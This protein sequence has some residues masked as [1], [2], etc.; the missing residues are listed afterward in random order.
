MA[1][2]ARLSQGDYY[3]RYDFEE[4]LY[5]WELASQK[6]FCKFFDDAKEE[7]VPSNQRLLNDA[8]RFGDEITAEQYYQHVHT[9][10]D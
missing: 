7:Q 9:N 2:A 8:I 10:Q 1:S 6:W 5:R 4:V 3:V